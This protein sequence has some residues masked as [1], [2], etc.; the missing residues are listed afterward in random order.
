MRGQVDRQQSIFVVF[1]LEQRVP[2]E[3]PLRK[4]KRWADHVLASMSRDFNKAYGTT[5]KPGIPPEQLLKALLLQALYSIPSETKL[6][7]AIEY[8]VLYRWFLDLPMEHH[9][10]TQEAFSMNR[11]RFEIHDLHRKFFD[12][13]V[14]ECL[15]QSLASP[16]HF[17]IDGTLIRSLASHKSLQPIGAVAGETAQDSTTKTKQSREKKNQKAKAKDKD[18]DQDG[19]TRDELVDWQGQKRSNATH[20]STTDPDARLARKGNGREAH[21]CHS[22]HV[23]MDNRS[24]LCLNV[25]VDFADGHAERRNALR[26]L[27][28]LKQRHKLIP[29]TAGMD[30]GYKAGEFLLEVEKHGTVPHVP[31]PDEPIR[32]DSPQAEARRR[33]RRRR[34]TLGYRLSQRVRKRCEQIIGWGKTVA[35]LARTRFIGHDRIENSALMAGAA[36]NLLRMTR[37]M[38]G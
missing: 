10:W 2:M 15:D 34:K 20:R 28:Q 26:M 17:S 6:V 14:A 29:R 31:M 37:L 36:Y 38:P 1:D 16:D 27:T 23:M 3:H 35:G 25:T 24:G 33:A 13:V 8:N 21:L 5:G 4:I 12:R 9:A 32:G 18:K 22:G 19:G 30:M 7:E 11:D